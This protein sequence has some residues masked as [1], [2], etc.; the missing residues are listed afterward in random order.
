MENQGLNPDNSL[1]TIKLDQ[2]SNTL[3]SQYGSKYQ[4]LVGKGNVF[5]AASQAATT[6]SVALATTHT[7]LVLSNPVNSGKNLVIL[8]AGFALSVAPAAISHIGL[9]AGFSS[10]GITVHTTP[11]AIQNCLIGGAASSVNADGAATLVG[12]ATWIT[13]IMG[14]FTAAALPSTSPSWIDV[15]GAIVVKPG[16]YFGI[17]ALTASVG[18]GSILWAEIEA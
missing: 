13:P 1:V 6:W 16:G 9:F 14:G 17:G 5:Y 18:F 8:K 12:T 7:G 10:A 2:N 15:D 3:V 11:L 4:Y